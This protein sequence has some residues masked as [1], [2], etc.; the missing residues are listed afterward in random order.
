MIGKWRNRTEDIALYITVQFWNL[1]KDKIF[2]K[3]PFGV[4]NLYWKLYNFPVKKVGCV[5]VRCKKRQLEN[6]QFKF[7]NLNRWG[8]QI[9]GGKCFPDSNYTIA[10]S[11]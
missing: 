3:F 5:T 1:Y 11:A 8:E 2:Q 7:A 6:T 10:G 9:A 4:Q